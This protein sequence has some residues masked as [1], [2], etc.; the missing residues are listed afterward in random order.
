MGLPKASFTYTVNVTIFMS[1]IFHLFDV[2]C[3]QHHGTA[4]NPFLNATKSGENDG[5]C[6]RTL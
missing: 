3:K 1:G 4:F 6:K 5:T 2:M